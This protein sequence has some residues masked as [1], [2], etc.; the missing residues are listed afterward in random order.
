VTDAL[1]FCEKEAEK[2]K[3]DF[4][5]ISKMAGP[6]GEKVCGMMSGFLMGCV[7]GQV[8]KNCPK[9]KF[10]DNA[11]CNEIKAFVEKCTFLF[12]GP[13]GPKGGK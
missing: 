12:P 13:K 3:A 9:D 5:E 2:K 1:D 8:F 6:P 7:H 4:D 11:E 10:E